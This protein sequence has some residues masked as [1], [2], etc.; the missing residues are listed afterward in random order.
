MIFFQRFFISWGLA[1]QGREAAH[2]YYDLRAFIRGGGLFDSWVGEPIAISTE[3]FNKWNNLR[4]VA[5][6]RFDKFA[7]DCE[8]IRLEHRDTW[9]Y[10]YANSQQ[11]GAEIILERIRNAHSR[12]LT[13]GMHRDLSSNQQ[14]ALHVDR[15]FCLAGES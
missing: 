11:A 3:D 13:V 9:L 1:L 2:A 10:D 14:D 8:A 15:L 5:K 12:I 4:L 7:G 6:S